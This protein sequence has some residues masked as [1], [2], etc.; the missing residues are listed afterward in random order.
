MAFAGL[1]GG[2]V[3]FKVVSLA[4]G[5]SA[6]PVAAKPVEFPEAKRNWEAEKQEYVAKYVAEGVKHHAHHH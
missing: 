3:L 1:F 4:F 6:K 2:Y 5:K